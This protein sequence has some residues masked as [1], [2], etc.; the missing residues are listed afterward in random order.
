MQGGGLFARAYPQRMYETADEL[1][2]RE[3]AED[4]AERLRDDPDPVLLVLDR[5]WGSSTRASTRMR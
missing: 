3:W 1:T 4:L 5:T 2:N